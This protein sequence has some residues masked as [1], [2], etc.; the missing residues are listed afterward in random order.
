MPGP[1]YQYES[2][3][4]WIPIWM[5]QQSHS[6]TML[7]NQVSNDVLYK[8]CQPTLERLN[9]KYEHL[10]ATEPG[11]FQRPYIIGEVAEKRLIQR[12]VVQQIDNKYITLS[13]YEYDVYIAPNSS[14][15]YQNKAIPIDIR[16]VTL[17]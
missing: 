10:K 8:Q 7:V 15:G 3:Y 5:A 17:R 6:S 16:D 13:E 2:Y 11:L 4:Q 9:Q 1:S 12:R 14:D